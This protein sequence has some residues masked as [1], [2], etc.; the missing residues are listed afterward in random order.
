M[1]SSFIPYT[2]VYLLK[3]KKKTFNL[4]LA[5][6]YKKKRKKYT[7]ITNKPNQKRNKKEGG[8]KSGSPMKQ[9]F[10]I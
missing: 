7:T 3:I 5:S 9:K 1:Q 4:D 10:C 8:K 2:L 6:T